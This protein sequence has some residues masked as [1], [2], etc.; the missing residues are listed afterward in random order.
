MYIIL[1]FTAFVIIIQIDAG[2]GRG[3]I[4]A[5][6]TVLGI[7]VIFGIVL[8][9]VVIGVLLRRSKQPTP[10]KTS[11]VISTRV[12]ESYQKIEPGQSTLPREPEG[13]SPQVNIA[14]SNIAQQS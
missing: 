2:L 8:V 5:I 7:A 3:E 13:N 12:N 10:N 9:V 6:V 4:A 11:F 14:I 1:N